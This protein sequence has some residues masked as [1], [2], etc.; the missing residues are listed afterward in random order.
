MP[1]IVESTA[2]TG[3]RAGDEDAVA[4]ASAEVA[5]QE[6]QAFG[7][8]LLLEHREA[9]DDA[10]LVIAIGAAYSRGSP[11]RGWKRATSWTGSLDSTSRAARI[12]AASAPGGGASRWSGTGRAGTRTAAPTMVSAAR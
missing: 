11:T 7:G 10:E 1:L 6:V 8:R 3:S 5:R 2:T 4:G 9:R 12:V